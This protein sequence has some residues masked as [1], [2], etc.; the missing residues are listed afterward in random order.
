MTHLDWVIQ[1]LSKHRCQSSWDWGADLRFARIFAGDF[2]DDI[3]TLCRAN[4]PTPHLIAFHRA[5]IYRRVTLPRLRAL[6][7][8]VR[9]G[10]VKATWS[11]TD[12][13]GRTDFG[14]TRTRQ[15]RLAL[16]QCGGEK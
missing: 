13:G 8:L 3:C 7:N 1:D 12:Y 16:D 2:V 11:G 15:Y 5:Y 9:G 4:A 6:R 14:V 10:K